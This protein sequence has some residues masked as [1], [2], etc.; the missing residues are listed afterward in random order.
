M[1]Y[2]NP[3]SEKSGACVGTWR[4][5]LM[6]GVQSKKEG[7]ERPGGKKAETHANYTINFGQTNKMGMRRQA[8]S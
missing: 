1:S 3:M 2:E 4:G 6:A 7:R 8:L 5:L